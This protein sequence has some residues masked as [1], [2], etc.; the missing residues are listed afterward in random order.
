MDAHF[1]DATLPLD[2]KWVVLNELKALKGFKNCVI[3]IHDF[4]CSGLG[5]C[6]YDGES[7]S[8]PLLKND[9]IKIN[10][11]FYLYVN[12]I[13]FCDIHTIETIYKIKELIVN[14]N[15]LDTIRL[16]NSCDRLKYRGILYCVPDELNLDIFKL[17][18]E[19]L[20]V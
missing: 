9:I 4:D 7:L 1:Y 14:E 18:R 6:C 13:D 5:H 20:N 11:D 16:A 3:C 15:V 8:L 10:K 12:A 2:K 17:N 19:Y